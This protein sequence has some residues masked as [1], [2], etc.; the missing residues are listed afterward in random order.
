MKQI[1]TG[2]GPVDS[3][4][5]LVTGDAQYDEGR[6]YLTVEEGSPY[7]YIYCD[8]YTIRFNTTDSSSSSY[9]EILD[10]TDTIMMWL[11]SDIIS[12]GTTYL[13]GEEGFQTK[14]VTVVSSLPSRVVVDIKGVHQT[15]SAGL[16]NES[17]FTIRFHIYASWFTAEA[18]LIAESTGVIVGPSDS[19]HL[20]YFDSA[21]G[22]TNAVSINESSGVEVDPGNYT[23]V[24]GNYIGCTADQ[25]NIFGVPLFS[26]DLALMYNRESGAF[27]YAWDEMTLTAG[28]HRLGMLINIDSRDRLY[29]MKKYTVTDRLLMGKQ[30]HDIPAR[31]NL[32]NVDIGS[33][34]TDLN[35]PSTDFGKPGFGRELITDHPLAEGLVGAWLMNEGSGT[36]VADSLGD[37]DLT[38]T[39]ATFGGM[40]LVFDGADNEA[41]STTF[42]IDGDTD[43]TIVGQFEVG[44]TTQDHLICGQWAGGDGEWLLQFDNVSFQSANTDILLYAQQIPTADTTWPTVETDSLDVDTTYRYAVVHDIGS[45]LKIY[46]DGVE[47][48]NNVYNEAN[49]TSGNPNRDFTV[50]EGAG[51]TKDMLGEQAFLY[52]YNR[53]LSAKEIASL[54]NDPYQMFRHGVATDGAQ[55]IEPYVDELQYATVKTT[56]DVEHLIGY[57]TCDDNAADTTVTDIFGGND[58]TL[59]GGSNTA[60]LSTLDSIRGRS[61]LLDGTDDFI[62]LS[63]AL[64]GVSDLNKF[65]IALKFKPNF[66]YDVGSDQYIISWRYDV[67]DTGYFRY[68]A[69]GDVFNAVNFVD[70]PTFNQSAESE[71]YTSNIQLQ[72]WHT[73]LLSFDLP[74]KLV[75]IEFNGTIIQFVQLNPSWGND[76]SDL[77]IGSFV[78]TECSIYVD[79]VKLYNNPILPYGTFI[80]SNLS[81][82]TDADPDILFHWNCES[83][84]TQISGK[85]M[86]LNG[87][88][89]LSASAAIAGA[90]GLDTVSTWE[91]YA[92]VP[93]ASSDIFNPKKGSISIWVNT[94]ASANSSFF[95]FGDAD[96][97]ISISNNLSKFRVTYRSQ[98]VSATIST[99][100][101]ITE[102]GWHHV[103]VTFDDSDK[104]H[105]LIDDVETG[106]GATIVNTWAGITT[107]TLY[108]GSNYVG[109]AGLDCYVDEI[110]ITNNPDTP[111]HAFIPGVGGTYKTAP[112]GEIKLDINQDSIN[113]AVVVHEEGVRTGITGAEEEHLIG[114]WKC[115]DNAGDTA[116]VDQLRNFP[117][118]VVQGGKNTE[119]MTTSDSGRDSALEFDGINDY[120]NIP[121]PTS[122]EFDPVNWKDGFT[123][124]ARYKPLWEYDNSVNLGVVSIYSAATSFIRLDWYP[125]S[126]KHQIIH[127]LNNTGS[128]YLRDADGVMD[129]NI[130]LQQYITV[131]VSVDLVSNRIVAS[132]DGRIA[133]G[134]ITT[135]WSGDPVYLVIGAGRSTGTYPAE[136]IVDEVRLYNKPIL[137]YGSFIP[138]NHGYA[139]AHSDILFHWDCESLDTQIPADGLMTVEA[140]GSIID[141]T[142][143]VS[144]KNSLFTDAGEKG[145]YIEVIDNDLC[146]F[147]KGTIGFW[148]YPD[149][150]NTSKFFFKIYD[151]EENF[152]GLQTNWDD[153]TEVRIYTRLG[154]TANQQIL[155]S[156]LPDLTWSYV[157]VQWDV[158]EKFQRVYLN[159]ELVGDETLSGTW[160]GDG[161][162]FIHLGNDEGYGGPASAWFDNFTITNNPHTPQV[163]FVIGK[164]P[165]HTPLISKRGRLLRAGTDY[166]MVSSI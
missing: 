110:T 69:N 68:R 114:Y 77:Y 8:G 83:L 87:S 118:G 161:N 133:V 128:I 92:S 14:A 58:G 157:V 78:G 138:V 151:D 129:S 52:I 17:S 100:E 166:N 24:T 132:F 26:T 22:L 39:G 149:T 85:T 115:N 60:D 25:M 135:E 16:P 158:L 134:T 3:G 32:P 154:D 95:S 42:S 82:Y 146:D 98:A 5:S 150:P 79:E 131:I 119:D 56:G 62:D 13:F 49:T 76:I 45:E 38:L 18:I 1:I 75:T 7:T 143:S 67:N 112:S 104:L 27:S 162:G 160:A 59:T 107:G 109:G 153:E 141:N 152:I 147:T 101:D 41:R 96:N 108:I 12:S 20:L 113:S 163:P 84:D 31:S 123:V 23:H 10:S 46:I 48:T 117:D 2:L 15:S 80:P 72:Q 36:N 53:V 125:T 156:H 139:N 127:N 148:V 81:S 136:V 122:G 61:I 86:T 33:A 47:A 35:I 29:G 88:A 105:L 71:V 63:S 102:G 111:Q 140:I 120:I 66:T 106:T 28:T 116:V 55:H 144:G 50:G 121:M 165:I 164:G 130:K 4:S 94:Q 90:L 74:N 91:D 65:T 54:H 89:N 21:P 70:S 73:V 103:R 97:N 142:V 99:V 40:G 57:W 37:N 30:Y 9:G 11:R 44:N 93:V 64:A 34:V 124:S 6:H 51:D 159:G 43:R 137:P 155:T 145:A 19:E 126:D